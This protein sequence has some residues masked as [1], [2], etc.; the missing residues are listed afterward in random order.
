MEFI[1]ELEKY[2]IGLDFGADQ[3]SRGYINLVVTRKGKHVPLVIID[4]DPDNIVLND[5]KQ[6]IS[7]YEPDQEKEVNTETEAVL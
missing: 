5:I 2:Y 3:D 6:I 7:R 4:V 1:D